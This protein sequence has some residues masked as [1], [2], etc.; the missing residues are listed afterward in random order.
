MSLA[1]ALGG[2]LGASN[3]KCLDE[4]PIWNT[5]RAIAIKDWNRVLAI[6]L[7]PTL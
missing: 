4:R 2:I 3:I 5:V 7:W 1:K 6:A